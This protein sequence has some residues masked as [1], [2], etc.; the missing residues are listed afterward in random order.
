MHLYRHTREYLVCV[1]RR[2]GDGVGRKGGRGH[3]FEDEV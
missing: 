2:V 3:S 1:W